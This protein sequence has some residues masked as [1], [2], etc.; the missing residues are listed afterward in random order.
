MS[1]R[2]AYIPHWRGEARS[3]VA[4]FQVTKKRER[5]SYIHNKRLQ[6]K[7][8]TL[9]HVLPCVLSLEGV[10]VEENKCVGHG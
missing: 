2:V 4:V 7:L 5:I 8:F 10:G 9:E 1:C 6:N 3:Q